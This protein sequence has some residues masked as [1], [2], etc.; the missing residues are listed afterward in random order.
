MK[1][2]IILYSLCCSLKLIGQTPVTKYYDVDWGTADSAKYFYKAVFT[3][4][5][6]G[7]KCNIYWKGSDKIA[8]KGTY[9]DASFGKPTGTF[10][11]YHKNGALEDSIIYNDE[12]K[13]QEQFKY[14]KNKQVEFRYLLTGP[15]VQYDIKAY[16]EEGKVIK[17]YIYEKEAEF[18]GGDKAWMSYIAKN[19]SKEFYAKGKEANETVTVRVMFCINEEGYPTK[20]KIQVSSG[21]SYV[22]SD[23]VRVIMNSPQWKNAIQYNKPV[24]A[25]RIQPITYQLIQEKK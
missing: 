13:I 19:A 15:N 21:L 3:S 2:L 23:A 9:E 18:K 16:D 12:H 1:T 6:E 8:G 25:Y 4:A 5:N 22:D 14:Y 7:F 20:V 24:K 10:I 11:G 17:G